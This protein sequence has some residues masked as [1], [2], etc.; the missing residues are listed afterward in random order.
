MLRF[1][2]KKKNIT[3]KQIEKFI[4]IQEFKPHRLYVVSVGD[5]NHEPTSETISMIF[6]KVKEGL[7]KDSILKDSHLIVF[8]YY[9]KMMGFETIRSETV[10]KNQLIIKPGIWNNF[11]YS[12]KELKKIKVKE[13]ILVTDNFEPGVQN[14]LGKATNFKYKNKEWIADIELFSKIPKELLRHLEISPRFRGN[15]KDGKMI[16]LTLEEI[17]IVR[18]SAIKGNKIKI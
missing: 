5:E 16:D 7:S 6:K 17:A 2:K 11:Y 8:P 4:K 9:S 1:G 18:E 3:M 12:A 13:P 15:S 10:I 14:V